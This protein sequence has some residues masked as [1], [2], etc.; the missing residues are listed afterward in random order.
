MDARVR[1]TDRPWGS[2][3][4]R[5]LDYPT[6]PAAAEELQTLFNAIET[7]LPRI[8]ATADS[9]VGRLRAKAE[10]AI[11]A[12]RAS[13]ASHAIRGHGEARIKRYGRERPWTTVGLTALVALSIGL[14]AGRSVAKRW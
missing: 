1:E 13:L 14:Y 2:D 11:A 6:A 12:A 10:R 3:A 7:L 4:V 9:E 5:V 8:D